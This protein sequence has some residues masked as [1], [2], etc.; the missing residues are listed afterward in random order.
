MYNLSYVYDLFV[1]VHVCLCASLRSHSII[2]KVYMILIATLLYCSYSAAK[3][4]AV[5]C[6]QWV[7]QSHVLHSGY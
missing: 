6:I 7:R 3:Y 2:E 4:S 1:D 5:D